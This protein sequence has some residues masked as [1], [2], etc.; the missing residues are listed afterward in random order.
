MPG[1]A[2]SSKIFE[3]I[4]LPSDKFELHYLDWLIP[5]SQEESLEKYTQRLC[6]KIKYRNPVLIGVSFG[7]IIVQEISKHIATKKVIIISSIKNK[8]EF[9]KRLKILKKTKIYK[10]FP[11]KKIAAIDDFSNYNFNNSFK[12]KTDLYN[13]YMDVRNEKYL[14]WAI[15]HVLH[16]DSENNEQD[17][18]HIHGSDD[19]IFPIKH[20][21]KC[22]EIKGGGHAMIITKAKR[23]NAILQEIIL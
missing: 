10:L 12:K 13:K 16:W 1:L 17:I 2:A 21:N 5:E 18:I 11:S 14:N 3:Y 23:I 6:Q 20:I 9:P 15:H 19:E 7:G 4:R 22:I 8:E